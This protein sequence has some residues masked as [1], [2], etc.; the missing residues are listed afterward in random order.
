MNISKE[1]LSLIKKFEG[2]ELEAYKCAAGV[3]T[4][5]YGST[6]GVKEGDTITQEEADKLLLHEME[7]YEGYVNKLV[8]VD[9]SQN[10]FDA[11]VSWV[12]NLGPANLKAS[13]LLK[14]LNSKD[15]E[16]VPAQ[17]QRWNKAGGKVLE[18]LIR[19]RNAEALLFEGKDWEHI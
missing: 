1:G 12:F 13:T 19:R 2:C 10:Q 3:L 15:Y 6:K 5:G 14:V 18:G 17:I 7:E 11:L 4:I 9:L 8:E 16:G